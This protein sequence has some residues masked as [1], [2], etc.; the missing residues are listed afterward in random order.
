MTHDQMLERLERLADYH[1]RGSC[2]QDEH[3]NTMALRRA[4]F[5][6]RHPRYP[7]TSCSQCGHSLGAGHYGSSH[8][9]HHRE[10]A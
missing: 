9:E 4:I 1:E 7:E 3:L 6:L 5:F 10:F 2:L 8:C